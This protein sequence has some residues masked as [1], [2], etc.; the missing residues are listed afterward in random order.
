MPG[1]F[2]A[3]ESAIQDEKPARAAIGGLFLGLAILGGQVQYVFGMAI[4]L[5]IY[6]LLKLFLQFRQKSQKTRQTLFYSAMIAGI[7][8]GIGTL[9]II[10]VSQL[11][12]ESQRIVSTQALSV[13]PAGHLNNS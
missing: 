8:L 13:A 2:W 7:G 6:T 4:M 9:L 12:Q 10:P 5:A 1:I 11:A 3:L